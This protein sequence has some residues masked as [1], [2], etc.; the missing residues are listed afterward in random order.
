MKNSAK[1]RI[2]AF[3][4]ILACLMVTSRFLPENSNLTMLYIMW[5]PGIAA[6]LTSLIT[7]K[8][9]KLVGWRPKWKWLGIGWLLP[10][11]YGSIAFGIIWALGLGGIPKDSF[12]ENGKLTMGMTSN[13]EVLIIIAAF[14]FISILNLLPNMIFAMGE[15]LGWR[16]FLVPE[17]NKITSFGKTAFFSGLI[18]FAWHLPAIIS[19]SYGAP[20]TPLWFQILCFGFLIFSGAVILAWLRLNSGSIWPCVI[21]HAVHNGVIQQFFTNLT[22]DTGVTKYF[23]G[24]FGIMVPLVLLFFAFYFLRRYRKQE[25]KAAYAEIAEVSN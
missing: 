21:F 17:L 3:I 10:V 7:W 5:M 20:G 13:S 25:S 8:S 19:G 18:W 22:S 9:L 12:I 1:M 11:V 14:F 4:I 6:L 2:L 24:E 23:I 15:E 16:G